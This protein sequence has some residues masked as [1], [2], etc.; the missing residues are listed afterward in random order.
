MR[1]FWETSRRP[2]RKGYYERCKV[3][4]G[5][6]SF[7]ELWGGPISQDIAE[8]AAKQAWVPCSKRTPPD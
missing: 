2:K 4:V 3:R 8:N 1:G 7:W 5:R 6:K